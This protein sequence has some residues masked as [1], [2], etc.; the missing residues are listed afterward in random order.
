[1]KQLSKQTFPPST[2]GKASINIAEGSKVDAPVSGDLW[3]ESGII[4]F[5]TPV[6]TKSLVEEVVFKLD[7]ALTSYTNP[8]IIGSNGE[9]RLI[10]AQST[11]GS[12]NINYV[13]G[14]TESNDNIA[15]YLYCPSNNAGLDVSTSTSSSKTTHQIASTIPEAFTYIIESIREINGHKATVILMRDDYG[16]D[17]SLSSDDQVL[18]TSFLTSAI[19]NYNTGN[20]A[21]SNVTVFSPV[22]TKIELHQGGSV[23]GSSNNSQWQIRYTG[24]FFTGRDNQFDGWGNSPGVSKSGALQRFT[25][26]EREYSTGIEKNIWIDAQTTS[27]SNPYIAGSN[28]EN[29]INFYD[30]LD[31]QTYAFVVLPCRTFDGAVGLEAFTGNKMSVEDWIIIDSSDYNPLGT[32]AGAVVMCSNWTRMDNGVQNAER[33]ILL[34]FPDIKYDNALILSNGCHAKFDLYIDKHGP[35][36]FSNRWCPSG[37]FGVLFNRT[38]D[39]DGWGNPMEV[40]HD[41]LLKRY[42]LGEKDFQSVARY[43]VIVPTDTTPFPYT[44]PYNI[45]QIYETFKNDNLFS[46]KNHISIDPCAGTGACSDPIAYFKLPANNLPSG[47]KVS[48]KSNTS[49]LVNRTLIVYSD[50]NTWCGQS[51]DHTFPTDPLLAGKT[52]FPINIARGMDITFTLLY[53]QGDPNGGWY[54]D[55]H[56]YVEGIGKEGWGNAPDWSTGL[57][58]RNT[59]TAKEYTLLNDPSVQLADADIDWNI[60]FS[61]YEYYGKTIHIDVY[62]QNRTLKL[63]SLANGRYVNIFAHAGGSP[64]LLTLDPGVDCT[65]NGLGSLTLP[66][67]CWIQLVRIESDN[68]DYQIIASSHIELIGSKSGINLKLLKEPSVHAPMNIRLGYDRDYTVTGINYHFSPT[69]GNNTLNVAV[70]YISHGCTIGIYNEGIV[71]LL[72]QDISDSCSIGGLPVFTLSPGQWAQFVQVSTDVVELKLV[73]STFATGGASL[74][75]VVHADDYGGNIETAIAA[76]PAGGGTVLLGNKRYTAPWQTNPNT[77][78]NIALIGTGSPRFKTD[79]TGLQDGTGTI[80]EGQLICDATNFTVKNLGI[81]VGSEV[82]TRLYAGVA[83]DAFGNYNIGQAENVNTP[84]KGWVVD[85]IS[86]IAQSPTALVHC[87]LLEYLEEP[88]IRNIRA[89]FGIHGIVIKSIGGD[90][91]HLEASAC[92]NGVYILASTYAKAYELNIDTVICKSVGTYDGGGVRIGS[93]AATGTDSL[94]AHSINITNIIAESTTYGIWV[95][96]MSSPMK[97]INITNSI[98]RKPQSTGI[99]ITSTGADLRNINFTDVHVRDG[100]YVGWYIPNPLDSAAV[101]L[102]GCSA[103]GNGDTGYVIQSKNVTMIACD[104]IGNAQYGR[105]CDQPVVSIG[106]NIYGNTVGNE[107]PTNKF[108]LASDIGLPQPIVGDSGKSLVVKSDL[109]YELQ[110][111]SGGGPSSRNIDG[112]SPD[113]VYLSSQVIDGGNP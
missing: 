109:T 20:F 2:S 29:K 13:D 70:Q 30:S 65:I 60:D 104:A 111:L 51:A 67:D 74:A 10:I 52:Y 87:M 82:C 37:D 61:F 14:F 62:A 95:E 40:N 59:L 21:Y 96:A 1:M 50:E 94:G 73:S 69:V 45:G 43:E 107:Y 24:S 83:K 39:G 12:T 84:R 5:Q 57:T 68:V 22:R 89:R 75:N 47:Y 108:K 58:V 112:G 36:D 85:D 18:R 101:K 27:P 77:Q 92:G 31:S 102:I 55:G 97:D 56:N 105:Y 41:N 98:V 46:K 100:L 99:S 44:S 4:K 35:T 86:A 110:T 26:T 81:D 64:Y 80:L 9:N 15:A 28:G 23:S 38:D 103:N 11:I 106:C 54:V 42:T 34:Q 63:G 76:L 72:L 3:N 49:T 7:P 48:F 8:Y 93:N 16:D 91:S 71:D 66:N 19:P 6:G 53:G 113:S 79:N 17:P 32:V 90:F 88:K 25:L 78:N 33:N